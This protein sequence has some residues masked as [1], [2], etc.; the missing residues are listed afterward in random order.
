MDLPDCRSTTYVCVCVCVYIYI[1]FIAVPRLICYLFTYVS[2]ILLA[3]L[4]A[5]KI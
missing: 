2:N 4:L 3:P 1:Y 5:Y